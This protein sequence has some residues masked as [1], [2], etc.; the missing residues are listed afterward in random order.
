M[1]IKIHL[2]RDRAILDGPLPAIKKVIN[3]LEN[4]FSYTPNSAHQVRNQTRYKLQNK[5]VPK[6]VIDRIMSEMDQ[7]V[8]LFNNEDLTFAPGLVYKAQ[9]LIRGT[10]IYSEI[11]DHI[12]PIRP[13]YNFHNLRKQFTP[14][15]HQTNALIHACTTLE[16]YHF[17]VTRMATGAGK[18]FTACMTIEEFGVKSMFIVPSEILLEQAYEDFI[19]FFGKEL[20]GRMGA[21][22]HENTPIVIATFQSICKSFDNLKGSQESEKKKKKR[23]K[24]G[25]KQIVVSPKDK[26]RINAVRE[27]Q[28]IIFD[29]VHHLPAD[30]YYPL[31][32]EF[33]NASYI[34]GYTATDRRGDGGNIKI[35]AASGNTHFTISAAELINDG[36]LVP[37]MIYFMKIPMRPP[38]QFFRQEDKKKFYTDYTN[39]YY[40]YQVINNDEC[41]YMIAERAKRLAKD[42]KHILIAINKIKH[43]ENILENLNY[44][45]AQLVSSKTKKGWDMIKAFRAGEYPI[46]I[47][48][49][50]SEGFNS[51]NIDDIIIAQDSTD[52]EQ[53]C[54]RGLRTNEGKSQ[55]RIDHIYHGVPDDKEFSMARYMPKHAFKCSELYR[56]NQFPIIQAMEP[57]Y[58]DEG[59]KD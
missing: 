33:E 48:T 9:H 11:I 5:N 14:R 1:S 49:L 38:P 41:N 12:P 42:G 39:S 32:M 3:I 56:S 54:G 44:S 7:T 20:V 46:L 31:V 35:E 8:R 53:I 16:K 10:G 34:E 18:T 2:H 58:I 40:N 57:E 6:D 13:E 21:G 43:G 51:P 17:M 30:K 23:A 19:F 24:E 29:E 25:K 28:L 36:F 37:P 55:C 26:D 22:Y 59:W 50:C 27:T 47:S 45:N 52:T 15:P 4:E